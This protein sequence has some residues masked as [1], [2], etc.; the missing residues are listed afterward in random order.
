MDVGRV[1]EEVVD[2]VGRDPELRDE[3]EVLL[4]LEDLGQ[5]LDLRRPGH[6]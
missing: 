3:L 5:Q 6:D 4:A 1:A 2:V